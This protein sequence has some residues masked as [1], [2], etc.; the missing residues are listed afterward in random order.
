MSIE[1]QIKHLIEEY[2]HFNKGQYLTT[3]QCVLKVQQE[4]SHSLMLHFIMDNFRRLDIVLSFDITGLQVTVGRCCLTGFELKDCVK[5][6]SDWQLMLNVLHPK[7]VEVYQVY[8][9]DEQAL[10]SNI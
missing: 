3:S 2:A 7:F 9:N 10:Q 1:N 8:T 5:L 4:L 6:F